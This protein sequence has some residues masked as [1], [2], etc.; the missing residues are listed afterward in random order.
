MPP[1]KGW[2]SL[3]PAVCNT[4]TACI[5]C[6]VESLCIYYVLLHM[7]TH[8][9]ISVPGI[10]L[11]IIITSTIITAIIVIT[12]ITIIVIV[13]ILIIIPTQ[14]NTCVLYRCALARKQYYIAI[15]AA[16]DVSI[17]HHSKLHHPLFSLAGA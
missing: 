17:H 6:T 7:H 14:R 10:S 9:C 8:I 11:C 3:W 4:V 15:N 5:T 12:I 16:L 13:I 2:I 1:N